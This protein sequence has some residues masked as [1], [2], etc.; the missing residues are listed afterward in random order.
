M[1]LAVGT[2]LAEANSSSWDPRFTF[3]IPPTRLIHIDADVA[4]IGRNY[5]DR[6]R[7]GRRREAGARARWRQRGAGRHASRPRRAARRDRARPPG[8]CRELGRPVELGSVP[9]AARAHSERAAQGRAR[10]RLHRHRRRLEQERRRRSSFRSPCP[11]RSSRRAAWRR[12]GSDRRRCSASSSR[13]RIARP[14]RS[15]ATAASARIR[16]S[17]ATAMEADLPRR[18][19]RHG[20]RRRS[21]PSPGSRTMHYG[22]SSAACSSADGEPYRVD[23]AAMARSYGAAASTIDVGRRARAGAARSARVGPADG[24]PGADGERADA[25]ARAL[26]HQRHLSRGRIGATVAVPRNV[27]RPAPSK[28]SSPSVETDPADAT[29]AALGRVLASETF[30]QADRLKRFLTFIVERSDRGPADRIERVRHRRACISQ[31]RHLRSA[32][33][34]DRARAGAPASR[35]TG[36]LLSRR[37]PGRGA[38]IDLPKGGYAPLFK[39]REAPTLSSTRRP[40][41]V[42]RNT[43]SVQ[44][45]SN[46]SAEQSFDYFC[47]ARPRRGHPSTGPAASRSS[48]RGPLSTPTMRCARRV[49]LERE[50]PP[51]QRAACGR[52]PAHRR[53]HAATTSGPSR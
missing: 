46:H 21:A 36:S 41:L 48:A 32:H 45:F 6:A 17:I 14:S 23:Y 34:P 40:A 37:R 8:V 1:I 25:D 12:W 50:R 29:R 3:A 26:G 2:R 42:G 51:V 39:P 43:M 19:A 49:V 9:D 24:D 11:A 7:R 31:G 28:G 18:L 44:P 33:G 30:Q 22:W 10:G 5:P 27:V 16:R 47:K 35:E 4:E 52:R 38:A 53:R 13:S 15:S 20:Q